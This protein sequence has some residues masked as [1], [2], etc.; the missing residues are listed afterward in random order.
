MASKLV[1]RSCARRLSS[2]AALKSNGGPRATLAG[3]NNSWDLPQEDSLNKWFERNG[4]QAAYANGHRSNTTPNNNNQSNGHVS[5]GDHGL[6]RRSQKWSPVV[7]NVKDAWLSKYEEGGAESFTTRT[8]RSPRNHHDTSHREEWLKKHQ[9][10]AARS[11]S[12]SPTMAADGSRRNSYSDPRQEWLEKHGGRST[13]SSSHTQRGR[14]RRNSEPT[15]MSLEERSRAEWLRKYEIEGRSATPERSRSASLSRPGYDSSRK[16]FTRDNRR[17][18]SRRDVIKTGGDIAMEEWL[19]KYRGKAND[20]I[21]APH[22]TPGDK[23]Y[24]EWQAKYGTRYESPRVVQQQW[25]NRYK[26]PKTSVVASEGGPV[27]KTVTDVA[28]ITTSAASQVLKAVTPLSI[29]AVQASAAVGSKVAGK[30]SA[31]ASAWRS[32][33]SN[34][35][36]QQKVG[37]VM[38]ELQR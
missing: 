27:M 28:Q 7:K 31:A 34:V 11:R 1:F 36:I 17:K 3:S 23:A 26:V 15:S 25:R 4:E 32:A 30:A 13:S 8:D 9:G 35:T 37:A 24:R 20:G 5:N 29:S 21:A 10:G 2:S 12:A 38:A 18:F 16:S 6:S 22:S 33:P 14:E 19:N